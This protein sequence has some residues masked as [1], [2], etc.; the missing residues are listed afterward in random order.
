MLYHPPNT[1]S[2]ATYVSR[3][4]YGEQPRLGS[5]CHR[6]QHTLVKYS[7]LG[8]TDTGEFWSKRQKEISFPDATH[9]SWIRRLSDNRTKGRI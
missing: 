5:V 7:R 8:I 6:W 3:K 1:I 9:S 4:A 2:I